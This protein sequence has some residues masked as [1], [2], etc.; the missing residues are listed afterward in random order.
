MQFT[1]SKFVL[2]SVVAVAG[3]ATVANA[4]TCSNQSGC[5]TCETDGSM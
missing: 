4:A 1:K 5:K 2:S 3:L